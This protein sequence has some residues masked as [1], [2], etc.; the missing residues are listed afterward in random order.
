VRFGN[1]GNSSIA[2]RRSQHKYVPT[3]AAV[4]KVIGYLRPLAFREALLGEGGQQV[5]VGMVRDWSGL[6]PLMRDFGQLF[7]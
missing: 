5:G 7:H 6:E 2:F 3:V 4:R 1:R